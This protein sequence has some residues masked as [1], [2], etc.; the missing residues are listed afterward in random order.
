MAPG[1]LLAR[2]GKGNTSF[3]SRT[4]LNDLTGIRLEALTDPHQPK[5][6]PG[7]ADDG[8]FVLTE[9][10]LSVATATKPD[11]TRPIQLTDAQATFNQGNFDVSKAVDGKDDDRGWAISPQIGKS[12]SAIFAIKEPIG[13][14]DASI[15]RFS[16][17]QV[18]N[19]GKHSLGRLRVAVTNSPLPHRLTSPP[20]DLLAVLN[21]PADQRTE[22]QQQTLRKHYRQSDAELRKIWNRKCRQPKDAWRHKDCS[23]LRMLL[24]R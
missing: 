20:D 16:L 6:G 18:Y 11:D 3:S 5:N 23:A 2:T 7:R 1:R 17:N 22:T 12:Q 13:Q 4:E 10:R 24:G 15:L 9:I 8:N 14:S 19:S 21:T